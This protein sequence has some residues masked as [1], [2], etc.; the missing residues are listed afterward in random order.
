MYIEQS[1][2][3]KSYYTDYMQIVNNTFYVKWFK[4]LRIAILNKY[5]PLEEMLKE[6]NSPDFGRNLY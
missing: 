4:D 6:N 1:I 3:V 5:F 2:K